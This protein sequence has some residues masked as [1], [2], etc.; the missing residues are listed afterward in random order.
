MSV[1]EIERFANDVKAS[2]ALQ[3]ELKA[4][5]SDVD[6]LVEVAKSKGYDFTA[7]ELKAHGET[8]KGEL[9]E[10]DLEKAAAGAGAV[11]VVLAGPSLAVAAYVT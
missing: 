6:K 1:A 7:D 8:K 4:V 9:S 2:E 10:E 3:A 5:G 11:L